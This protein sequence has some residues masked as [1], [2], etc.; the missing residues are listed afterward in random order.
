MVKSKYWKVIQGTRVFTARGFINL[1][2][3]T[4]G[5]FF[6]LKRLKQD[7]DGVSYSLVSATLTKRLLHDSSTPLRC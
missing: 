2:I 6:A 3:L 7:E 5:G 4:A 1:L